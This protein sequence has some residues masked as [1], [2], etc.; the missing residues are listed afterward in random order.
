M[1]ADQRRAEQFSVP[2][3]RFGPRFG[4]VDLVEECVIPAREQPAADKIVSRSRQSMTRMSRRQRRSQ[5]G[6]EGALTMEEPGID[7]GRRA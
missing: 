7:S 2:Y 6:E 3:D 5:L 4:A 1:R